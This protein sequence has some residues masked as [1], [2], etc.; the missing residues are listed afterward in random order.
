M[1]TKIQNYFMELSK[2][3]RI[4]PIWDEGKFIFN[5]DSDGFMGL[6]SVQIGNTI[7]HFYYEI[8]YKELERKDGGVFYVLNDAFYE[9][10]EDVIEELKR[11]GLKY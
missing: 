4:S 9:T 3:W 5:R 6:K 7:E 2:I 8:K 10:P 11:L 1:D